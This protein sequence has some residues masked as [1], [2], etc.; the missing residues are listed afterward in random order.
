MPRKKQGMYAAIC[1]VFDSRCFDSGYAFAP[2]LMEKYPPRRLVLEY[3]SRLAIDAVTALLGE[4][5]TVTA[6]QVPQGFYLSHRCLRAL[7]VPYSRVGA[8]SIISRFSFIPRDIVGIVYGYVHDN[9]LLLG[10]PHGTVCSIGHDLFRCGWFR[11]GVAHRDDGNVAAMHATGRSQDKCGFAIYSHPTFMRY[12]PGPDPKFDRNV[13]SFVIMRAENILDHGTEIFSATLCLRSAVIVD[14]EEDS[15]V[16]LSSI[17][18]IPNS[19][20][21]ILPHMRCLGYQLCEFK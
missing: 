14:E 8:P 15:S 16:W 1:D 21:V 18:E 19:G 2:L 10:W 20:S 9:G 13:P 6:P 5:P 17:R 11:Y 4:N 7:S 3:C 12:G